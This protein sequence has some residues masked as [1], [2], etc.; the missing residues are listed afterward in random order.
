MKNLWKLLLLLALSGLTAASCA[1]GSNASKT[2]LVYE[3]VS[4]PIGQP[5]VYTSSFKVYTASLGYT[6]TT[7]SSF[8][9]AAAQEQGASAASI[10]QAPPIT[11]V[12]P[13]GN[14]LSQSTLLA[15][16]NNVTSGF[17]SYAQALASQMVG[18][19]SQPGYLRQVGASSAIFN[20][21]Q[22]VMVQGNTQPMYL[23]W[24]EIVDS[25][26]R[27]RYGDAQLIPTAPN[28]VYAGYTS[29]AVAATLPA[30]FAYPQAGTILWYP[31]AAPQLTIIQTGVLTAIAA[32]GAIN[33]NGAFDA[34]VADSN[35]TPPYPAGCALNSTGLVGCDPDY[36]LKCMI[37][38]GS[39]PGCPPV[40]IVDS[41]GNSYTDF[42]S[43][44]NANGASAGYV[45]YTRSLTP[46][47]TYSPD[48]N[49]D[50][51]Q[52]AKVT[53][54]VDTRTWNSNG[55]N[56]CQLQNG[57]M[58]LPNPFSGGY[59][60]GFEDWLGEA[61]VY[62]YNGYSQAYNYY[63][64]LDSRGVSHYL[65][66]PWSLSPSFVYYNHNYIG[67]GGLSFP[68]ANVTG[69]AYQTNMTSVYSFSEYALSLAFNYYDPSVYTI[70]GNINIVLGTNYNPAYL[71]YDSC[72]V[73]PVWTSSATPVIDSC[74]AQQNPWQDLNMVTC[75]TADPNCTT[76]FIPVGSVLYQLNHP[77]MASG[78]CDGCN[79]GGPGNIAFDTSNFTS[80]GGTYTNTGRIGYAVQS[81]VDRYYVT[82]DGNYVPI[83]ETLPTI[84]LA[85]TQSTQYYNKTVTLPSGAT[86][87]SYGNIIIDPFNT[88]QLYDYT[89]DTVNLLPATSYIYVA[90]IFTN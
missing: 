65:A 45:D 15:D 26:G 19:P 74:G 83:N 63:V 40:P 82:P 35:A 80:S 23:V 68:Y 70:N 67:Y 21:Q 3:T 55:Y 57:L 29:K 53:V 87:A 48:S 17:P 9:L 37:N 11:A 86:S 7:G 41:N 8:N 89:N 34:P 32:G 20:Y 59:Q 36:G 6:A 43:L 28:F 4:Q 16:A 24:Q 76:V 31:I 49:G 88:T 81:V 13:S 73:Q 33:V 46:V 42:I 50:T 78:V 18:T 22:Q 2:V 56:N 66:R 25:N 47:Y 75:T 69:W 54:S 72:S 10:A 51:I 30:S 14:P 44:E 27:P 12:D 62:S 64:C 79:D 58:D 77:N 84:T 1:A 38:H 52:T 60:G 5:P 85:P 71:Y 39:D 61:V 90:P